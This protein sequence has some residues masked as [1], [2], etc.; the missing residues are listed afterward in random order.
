MLRE[1]MDRAADIGSLH[2]FL[3]KKAEKYSGSMVKVCHRCR[4]TAKGMS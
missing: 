3:D 2:A 1:R 4:H